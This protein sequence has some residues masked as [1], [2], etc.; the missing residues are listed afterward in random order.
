MKRFTFLAV[1]AFALSVSASAQVWS[2][3]LTTVGDAADYVRS[4]PMALDADNNTVVTGRYSLQGDFAFGSTTFTGITAND[5]FIAKYDSKGAKQ[6]VAGINGNAVFTAVTT[7][8]EGNI[9]AAGKF[10]AEANVCGT[11]GATKSI[12]DGDAE[13][14]SR[15]SS[16]IVKYDKNGVVKE[17]VS[18]VPVADYSV[19]TSDESFPF[20]EPSATISKIQVDGDKVYFSLLSRGAV[21]IGDLTVEDRY[22]DAGWAVQ[23]LNFAAIVSLNAS[24]LGSAEKVASLGAQDR[25]LSGVSYQAEDVNFTVNDGV[26]YAGFTGVGTL[27]LTT[28]AGTETVTLAYEEYGN[29]EHAFVFARIEGDKTAVKVYNTT[30]TDSWNVIDDIDKMLVYDGKLYVAGTFNVDGLFGGLEYKGGC[31]MFVASLSLSDL[32]L[33]AAKANGYDEED[34]E[35]N[36]EIMTGLFSDGTSL[37]LSGYAYVTASGAF[38]APLAYTIDPTTCDFTAQE[39]T[40]YLTAAT[41]NSACVVVQYGTDGLSYTYKC[42]S[43]STTGISE[44]ADKSQTIV[45]NGDGIAVAAPADLCVYAADGALVKS[46]KAATSISLAGLAKGVYVVKAGQQTVKINK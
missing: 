5:A 28:A 22:V 30:A 21:T 23:D 17:A 14:T 7:D 6:W 3:K 16:F 37:C 24:D 43:K 32:S 42:L 40:E 18:L 1:I 2:D 12:A 10:A 13:N 20:F 29:V 34:A 4:A 15:Y 25:V 11:D 33:N 46:A 36:A 35:H 31:D 8:T 45:R 27:G 19:V 44:V 41:E 26:I 9:Y 38:I 39:A